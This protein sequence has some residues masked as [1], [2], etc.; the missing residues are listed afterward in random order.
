MCRQAW[1]GRQTKGG[2]HVTEWVV[3]TSLGCEKVKAKRAVLLTVLL[4]KEGEEARCGTST[5]FGAVKSSVCFVN[6]CV[7]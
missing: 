6:E 3:C 7:L 4:V 1:K 2:A 5:G